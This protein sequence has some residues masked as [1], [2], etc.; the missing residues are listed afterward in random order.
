MADL[1]IEEEV[2]EIIAPLENDGFTLEIVEDEG[3]PAKDEATLAL[4][5]KIAEMEVT[6]AANMKIIEEMKG[7]AQTGNSMA[8]LAAEIKKMAVVAPV[9]KPVEQPGVDYAALFE[10]TD[11][12]FYN[13]PSKSVVDVM[14]PVLQSMDAKFN[15]ASVKSALNVSKLMVLADDSMK[16]DYIKYKPEVDKLVSTFPPSE[17]VY[18]RALKVVRGNH[19]EDIIA[20]Q[21]AAQMTAITEKA[22]AAAVEEAAKLKTTPQFT[23]ATTVQQAQVKKVVRITPRQQEIAR[24]FAITKGFPWKDQ[25]DQMWVINYLKGKGVI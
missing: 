24:K 6:Q 9:E 17:D 16:G 18:S 19:I 21:V 22:E 7:T 20:E 1:I 8:G 5:A 3:I 4:E 23:N 25:E 10:S 11:K 15:D 13:S 14:S 12:N 2:E